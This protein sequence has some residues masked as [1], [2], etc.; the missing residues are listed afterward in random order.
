[1]IPQDIAQSFMLL[2]VLIA[3]AQAS[4][5]HRSAG[6]TPRGLGPSLRVTYSFLQRSTASSFQLLQ[7]TSCEPRFDIFKTFS[8]AT[9]A[10]LL[11]FSFTLSTPSISNCLLVPLPLSMIPTE[12][13]VTYQR[14][15][16]RAQATQQDH[17][18]LFYLLCGPNTSTSHNQL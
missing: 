11:S 5:Y 2:T 3:A 16:P 1:M 8:Q 10:C 6:A 14:E 4:R 17:A 9:I 7:Y 15:E 13:K 12:C 18:S